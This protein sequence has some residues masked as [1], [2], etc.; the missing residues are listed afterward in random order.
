V[1]NRHNIAHFLLGF[2]VVPVC[3]LLGGMEALFLK[4]THTRAILCVA[5]FVLFPL[6]GAV[7]SRQRV[8]TWGLLAGMIVTTLV[9]AVIRPRV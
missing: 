3:A 5:F 8:L 2:F 9:W 6:V 7:R 1:L 4:W